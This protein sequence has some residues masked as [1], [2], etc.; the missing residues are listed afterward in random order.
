MT[1]KK[2]VAGLDV[3]T[4]GC[5]IAVFDECGENVRTYYTEYDTSHAGGLHEIDFCD[6]KNGVLSLLADAAKEYRIEALGVTSFGETFAMLDENDSVLAP[7]MLYTDPRGKEQCRRLESAVG[8]EKMTLLTGVKPNEMYSI[9]KIM[10]L[11]DEKPEAYAKC[12]K[13]LLGEDFI[14][15]TLCGKRQI[16]FSLAARSGA[17]DIAKKEWSR[18]IFDAAGVDVALMSQPCEAGSFAGKLSYDLKVQLGIEYDI[19]IINGCHDQVAAMIGAGVFEKGIAMDGTG[20]VECIPVVLDEIPQELSVYDGGYSVVPF[21]NGKYACYAL[22]FT[23]GATLKWFRDNLAADEYEKCRKQRE[24]I[25]AYLDSKVPKAPTDILVL[26]HFAGAA[27]PYMDTS[28]KAAFVGITLET[29]KYD[30]YKAL[31]EGTSYE[32]LLNFNT[33]KSFIGEVKEIRATGGGA[34]SKVWLQIKA[35]ILNTKLCAMTCKEVGAAG[36]AALAGKSCGIY[37]DLSQAIS[38]LSGVAKE[39][40]PDADRAK[41]Y[42]LQY[43]RYKDL[44]NVVSSLGKGDSK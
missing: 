35:D 19:N 43:E 20:T 17:F 25:Y 16:D 4:T 42:A 30:L 15:Y 27:T 31:M 36:T 37:S 23:G 6:V 10:W 28:S 24:N 8:A 21:I 29:T 12:K 26:P 41:I 13:I 32:I 40:L 39:Y 9:S 7:S 1:D 44:Y 18:E 11:K 3:G 33:L 5:K 22:S 14:V 34:S 38:K 2:Y